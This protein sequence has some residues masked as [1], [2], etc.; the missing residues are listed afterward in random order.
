MNLTDPS[1]CIPNTKQ[2]LLCW[3]PQEPTR[4]CLPTTKHTLPCRLLFTWIPWVEFRSLYLYRSPSLMKPSFSPVHLFFFLLFV[5]SWWC[6]GFDVSETESCY[7]IQAD[8]LCLSLPC[9][10]TIGMCGSSPAHHSP[11]NG[12]L[13][14]HFSVRFNTRQGGKTYLFRLTDSET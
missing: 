12:C 13:V 4:L 7:I 5:C 11:L 14:I 10:W 2:S 1:T 9:V 8:L 6:Y 3:V